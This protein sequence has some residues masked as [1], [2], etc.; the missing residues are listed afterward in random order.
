MYNYAARKRDTLIA[1]QH[2]SEMVA[3]NFALILRS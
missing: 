1:T 2:A 3:S